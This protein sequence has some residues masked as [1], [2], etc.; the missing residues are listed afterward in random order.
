M[1]RSYTI[2]NLDKTC[3]SMAS[4][5]PRHAPQ[6]RRMLVDMR[7][8][9]VNSWGPSSRRGN[10]AAWALRFARQW[11]GGKKEDSGAIPLTASVA[12]WLYKILTNIRWEYHF[13]ILF[14]RWEWNFNINW[15][16][17]FLPLRRGVRPS[18]LASLTSFVIISCVLVNYIVTSA[19]WLAT[20]VLA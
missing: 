5:A 10:T 12:S 13:H 14:S 9:S 17:I 7:I 6:R 8:R 15:W 4:K 20:K 1:E 19:C 18:R 2:S 11:E 16:A 3:S